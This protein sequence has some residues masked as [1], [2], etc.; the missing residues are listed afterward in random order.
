M[1]RRGYQFENQI[2]KVLDYVNSIGGHAHKN[3]PERTVDGTYIRGESFDY[4]VFL[5]D[6]KAVFD[7]KECATDTW[8]MQKK[9]IVQAENLKHC[10]NVGLDAYFLIYFKNQGI[11]QIDIDKVV[12]IL[13]QGKKSINF[14]LGTEWKLLKIIRGK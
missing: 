4:E 3:H 2:N 6:Y 5:K 11:Y 7:A 8:H 9:D 10:K 12:D 14:N 1:P 13:G